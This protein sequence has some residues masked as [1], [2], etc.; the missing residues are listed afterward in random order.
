MVT[1]SKRTYDH[2]L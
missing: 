2:W 1:T